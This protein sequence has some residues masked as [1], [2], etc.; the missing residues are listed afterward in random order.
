MNKRERQR[1]R[2]DYM[3]EREYDSKICKDSVRKAVAHV[4]TF[5]FAYFLYYL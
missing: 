5:A 1:R 3:N 2:L 4:F